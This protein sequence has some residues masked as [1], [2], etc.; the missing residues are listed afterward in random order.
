MGGRGAR[1]GR[2]IARP[3]RA[4]RGLA[5]LDGREVVFGGLGFVKLL[6][7]GELRAIGEGLRRETVFEEQR[8][9]G[10]ELCVWPSGRNER[11]W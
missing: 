10:M 9:D 5:A 7:R 6:T 2:A 8:P 3:I 11:S 4:A 1:V